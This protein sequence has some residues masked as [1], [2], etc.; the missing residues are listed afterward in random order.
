MV[1]VFLGSSTADRE[2]SRGAIHMILPGSVNLTVVPRTSAFVDA[3]GK[4]VAS[5]Q[6]GGYIL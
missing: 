4:V 3:D 2:P 5:N 1:E 6:T